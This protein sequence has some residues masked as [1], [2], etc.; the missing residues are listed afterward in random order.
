MTPQETITPAAVQPLLSVRDQTRTV[1]AARPQNVKVI[2]PA[3]NIDPATAAKHEREIGL[4]MLRSEG[5]VRTITKRQRSK[6]GNY[7]REEAAKRRQ[8]AFKLILLDS[9]RTTELQTIL[10]KGNA[11]V[12]RDLEYLENAGLVMKERVKRLDGNG[13]EYSWFATG[14]AQ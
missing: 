4:A 7:E 12:R 11:V 3:F 2:I 8:R 9:Y 1:T 5:R 6:N 14:A 10:G 13:S